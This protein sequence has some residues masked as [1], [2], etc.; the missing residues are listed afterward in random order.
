MS[1][2]E[3]VMIRL[4]KRGLLKDIMNKWSIWEFQD[5]YSDLHESYKVRVEEALKKFI[6][7]DHY[8]SEFV[9]STMKHSILDSDN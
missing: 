3:C 4:K 5:H 8:S 9:M 1:R 7:N 2:V 6:K